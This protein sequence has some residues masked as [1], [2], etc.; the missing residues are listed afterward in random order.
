MLQKI[1]V[2]CV[3]DDEVFSSLKLAVSHVAVSQQ[4]AMGW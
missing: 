2:E 3:D 4:A 1:N